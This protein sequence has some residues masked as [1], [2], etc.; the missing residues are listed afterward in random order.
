MDTEEGWARFAVFEP[1]QIDFAAV[2]DVL[3]SANYVL[4]GIEFETT[5][6]VVRNGTAPT[7]V[8]AQTA[9]ELPLSASPP[10]EGDA[11]VRGTVEGWD[12]A[13]PLIWLTDASPVTPAGSAVGL[14]PPR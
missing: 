1:T 14:P 8:V 9:Q 12:Q 10:A 5:G 6:R 2:A 3:D 7:L 4:R 11:V 13:R